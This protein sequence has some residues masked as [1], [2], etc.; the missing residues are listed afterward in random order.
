MARSSSIDKLRAIA[1]QRLIDGDRWDINEE[2]IR[3]EMRNI[4]ID[5]NWGK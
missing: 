4:L 5:Y 1:L 3:E 2:N